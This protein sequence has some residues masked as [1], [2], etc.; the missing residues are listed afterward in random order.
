[1]TTRAAPDYFVPILKHGFTVTSVDGQKPVARPLNTYYLPSGNRTVTAAT[2]N[3]QLTIRTNLN[4]KVEPGGEYLLTGEYHREGV[5][6]RVIDQS[7]QKVVAERRGEEFITND[8]P[9]VVPIMV[10]AR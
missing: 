5:M 3:G 2:V 10:P 4:L 8:M 9:L 7:T 1:M 6:F